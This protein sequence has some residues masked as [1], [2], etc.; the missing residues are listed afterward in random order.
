MAFIAARELRKALHPHY[1]TNIILAFSFLFLKSV[2]PFCAFL[3]DSC[4][5]DYVSN[6]RIYLSSRFGIVY[7]QLY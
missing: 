5:L 2:P 6:L 7:M 4:E 1:L 3:F